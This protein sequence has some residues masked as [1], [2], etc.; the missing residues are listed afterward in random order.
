MH[1]SKGTLLRQILEEYQHFK[2]IQNRL[3]IFVAYHQ[4][5]IYEVFTCPNIPSSF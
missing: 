4:K 2:I 5:H 1:V 3:S